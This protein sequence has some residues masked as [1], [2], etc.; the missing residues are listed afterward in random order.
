MKE[1]AKMILSGLSRIQSFLFF[2]I[3]ARKKNKARVPAFFFRSAYSIK[4]SNNTLLVSGRT[5]KTN[6]FIEG[7]GNSID[8]INT[9][10]NET[11]ITV[12]GHNNRI[13]CEAGVLL[14][15]CTL[16]IR[17]NN[18][19]IK[20]GRATTFGGARIISA[21]H[22]NAVTIGEGCLFADFIEI[23]ASDTHPIYNSNNEI[24]NK[25]NSIAIGDKVWVGARAIILKGVTIASGSIV[26]MGSLVINN[27]PESCITAGN[28][29]RIIKNDVHW[30][31]HE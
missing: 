12:T 23:W 9:G 24:V 15:K 4:G 1:Y 7:T 27:V 5:E 31:L 16:T 18:C 21:G 29:N 14:R 6:F 26:G 28:P 30:A 3:P 2:I 10:V 13:E 22:D 8:L 19:R 17:G 25:E 20:I 11:I